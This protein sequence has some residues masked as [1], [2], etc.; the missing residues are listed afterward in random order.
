M[1]IMTSAFVVWNATEIAITWTTPAAAKRN[2]EENDDEEEENLYQDKWT[3]ARYN[4]QASS[5]AFEYE[6]SLD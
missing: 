5:E 6:S 1:S 2:Q 4:D 3:V